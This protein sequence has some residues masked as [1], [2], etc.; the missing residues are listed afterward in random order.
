[1]ASQCGVWRLVSISAVA[2][3][4]GS[5]CVVGPASQAG[6]QTDS[7]STASGPGKLVVRKHMRFGR[8]LA[9]TKNKRG[10]G[11]SVT[12][13]LV[14]KDKGPGP[15]T[16]SGSP[17]I[18]GG[19]FSVTTDNTCT[20]TLEKHQKCLISVQFTPFGKGKVTGTLTLTDDAQNGPQQVVK[21]VGKGKGKLTCPP[22]SPP[23][24]S[25]GTPVSALGLSVT[26]AFAP[27]SFPIA[28]PT[29]LPTP[30]GGLASAAIE[31]PIRRPGMFARVGS[32]L[33]RL[34][35]R[36]WRDAGPSQAFAT[37]PSGYI[38]AYAPLGSWAESPTGVALIQ[39]AGSG[40]TPGVVST[41]DTVN[42][43]AS[44]PAGTFVSGST[45]P[46]AVCVSN[47]T[48]V[49]L[50]D[51]TN[52]LKTLTSAGISSACF[53][54][55]CCT[56]CGVAVDAPS[57]TAAVSIAGSP[58]GSGGYQLLDLKTQS[59]VGTADAAPDGIAE[60]F[61]IRSVSSNYFEILSP[62]EGGEYDIF[63]VVPPS[64][65]SGGGAQIYR[66]NGTAFTPGQEEFDS[67]ALDSTG[68]L[69]ASD[70]FTNN[71]FLADLTQRTSDTSTSPPTWNAASQLQTLP[72]D[73]DT[74]TAGTTGI[75]VAYGDH[76]AFL[77][78][79]YGTTAFGALQLPAAS[80]SGT[81]AVVDNVV[82]SMPND[83]SGAGWEMP[84]DPHG[85]AAAFASAEITGGAP[86]TPGTVVLGSGRGI[87][88]VMNDARTYVAVVDLGKL[89]AAPRDTSD[90][91][92]NTVDP[93]YDL[94]ANSVVT[95]VPFP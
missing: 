50:I 22:S 27:P 80:G 66:Y 20:G 58:S 4:V 76:L 46:E 81:P 67:A 48:D 6:A 92:P 73:W 42:S 64:G 90:G 49:Y 19:N 89:L 28:S 63:A 29:A 7:S 53:S 35:S 14:V 45:N 3:L 87:G 93:S 15:V 8:V 21:L 52:L 61:G 82:A 41:P 33:G 12:K 18:T 16:F 95:F 86:G 77:E 62:T 32:W 74:F 11:E 85:L 55:G 83:P 75:A 59:F 72:S 44:V 84:L 36:W 91:F 79:E 13:K 40:V 43:C 17:A 47:D 37:A 31:S 30:T 65:G 51:G 57:L 70:E 1:M 23:P 26:G 56:T 39:I 54:G 24:P 25:A 9:C 60:T 69:L 34:V 71:I 5:L 38:A 78:D 88:V 2:L 68:I 94:L 10:K